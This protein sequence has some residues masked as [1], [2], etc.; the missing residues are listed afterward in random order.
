M[1]VNPAYSVLS[2]SSSMAIPLTL[3]A[4]GVTSYRRRR[5]PFFG[6]ASALMR[7]SNLS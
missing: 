4:H 3:A 1:A 2:C 7:E 6:A 5:T